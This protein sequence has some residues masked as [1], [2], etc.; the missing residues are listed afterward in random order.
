MY[1]NMHVVDM[2]LV[3]DL[4]LSGRKGKNSSKSV[5][6]YLSKTVINRQR[7]CAFM[8]VNNRVA[9]LGLCCLDFTSTVKCA[10][11]IM[12]KLQGIVQY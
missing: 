4:L 10:G 12:L 9:F 6:L 7:K 1:A 2:K 11:L 8:I 5:M 3:S